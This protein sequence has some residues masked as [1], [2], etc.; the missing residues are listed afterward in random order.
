MSA[1][2]VCQS[3]RRRRFERQEVECAAF[4]RTVH[5]HSA[6]DLRPNASSVPLGKGDYRGVCHEL[7]TTPC[8]KKRGVSLGKRGQ[9]YKLQACAAFRCAGRCGHS[10]MAHLE[11][12]A[13]WRFHICG[14]SRGSFV[15]LDKGIEALRKLR[16][17]F[18]RQGVSNCAEDPLGSPFSRG[19]KVNS[20]THGLVRRL[21]ISTL[22]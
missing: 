16:R 10:V 9:V 14:A 18:L 17:T 12:S 5:G 6:H 8:R 15:P 1:G 19:T 21:A 2:R 20:R 7:M 22:R 13:P 11:S 3:R 4:W